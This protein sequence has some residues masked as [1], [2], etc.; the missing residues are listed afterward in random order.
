[1]SCSVTDQEVIIKV[2]C[3]ALCTHHYVPVIS[4]RSRIAEQ[5][6]AISELAKLLICTALG[7]CVDNTHRLGAAPVQDFSH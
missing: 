4:D 5:A 2:M 1:V 7:I 3:W 6:A